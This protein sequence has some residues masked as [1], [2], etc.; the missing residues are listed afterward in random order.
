MSEED[1]V[2]LENEVDILMKADHPNIV[3]LFAIYEDDSSFYMVLEYMTG[4]EVLNTPNISY[5]NA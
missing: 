1:M 2:S 4:G 5:S 3:K